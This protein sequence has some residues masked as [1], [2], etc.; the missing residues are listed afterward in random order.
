MLHRQAA[1][2]VISSTAATWFLVGYR[3]EGGGTDHLVR[4]PQID[5][6]L[7]FVVGAVLLGFLAWLTT[8][9]QREHSAWLRKGWSKV[10][11]HLLVVGVAIAVGAR[12]VTGGGSGANIG[13]GMLLM[14]GP[15]P[16]AMLLGR[17]KWIV[18]GIDTGSVKHPKTVEGFGIAFTVVWIGL[19][20][21]SFQCGIC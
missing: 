19:I 17:A 18:A 8:G 10:Y 21:G 15:F 13:G 20:V 1:L 4:I 7:E 3:S 9:L 5:R 2:A 14:L 11:L 6:R 12:V 16:V